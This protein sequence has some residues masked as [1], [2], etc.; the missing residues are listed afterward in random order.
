M[1]LLCALLLLTSALAA[2]AVDERRQM[3]PEAQAT[4]DRV[5]EEIASGRDEKIYQ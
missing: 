3:P 2:C 1:R 4:I 5:T